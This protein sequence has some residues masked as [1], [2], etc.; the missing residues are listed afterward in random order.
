MSS[1]GSIYYRIKLAMKFKG[2][3]SQ[4]FKYLSFLRLAWKN[5]VAR[6]RW[7]RIADM[8]VDDYYNYQG[9]SK[10]EKKWAYTHGFSSYKLS[11]WYGITKDNYSDYMSDFVFYNPRYYIHTPELKALYEHKCCTYFTL[12]PFKESMPRHYFFLREGRVI[13]LDVTDKNDYDVASIIALIKERPIVA[14]ACVGGHGLG[15]FKLVHAKDEGI[16]IVNDKQ[17]KTEEE[18]VSL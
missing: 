9:A 1:C 13:P 15:F 16:F 10:Q 12:Q 5:G 8:Y 18:L 3:V 14:K 4:K 7:G 6:S 2:S 17:S 11:E